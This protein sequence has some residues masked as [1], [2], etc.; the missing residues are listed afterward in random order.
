MKTNMN[1]SNK[2]GL[3]ST[4]SKCDLFGTDALKFSIRT[5]ALKFSIRTDALK[6]SIR[7]DALKF[8]ILALILCLHI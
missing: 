8:S 5:D 3:R 7:T 4:C 2:N 1:I 6:F